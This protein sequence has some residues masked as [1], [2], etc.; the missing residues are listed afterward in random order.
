MPDIDK[1]KQLADDLQSLD[2][3]QTR[4]E[5]SATTVINEL[6]RLLGDGLEA[7]A[8]FEKETLRRLDALEGDDADN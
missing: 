7:V 1:L 6:K 5:D 2:D 8:R 4:Y 3:R